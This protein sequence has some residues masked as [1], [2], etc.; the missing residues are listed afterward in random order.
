MK[1]LLFRISFVFILL[2][3]FLGSAGLNTSFAAEPYVLNAD[4]LFGM[5][6]AH[7]KTYNLPPFQKDKALCDIATS[8]TPELYNEI[9]VNN[10]MHAGFYARNLP[11]WATEN[12]IYMRTEEDALRWWL[13]SPIHRQAIEGSYTHSCTAC[14]G[15]ACSEIFTN[16]T[17]KQIIASTP[18]TPTAITK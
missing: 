10:N 16:F 9:F 1:S 2:A 11:Y 12:M 5:V 13:N 8:R 18:P 7:R 17:P 15:Q 3:A 14:L 4:K 6:N